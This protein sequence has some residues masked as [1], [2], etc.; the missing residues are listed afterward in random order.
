M[1]ISSQP[2]HSQVPNLVTIKAMAPSTQRAIV[3]K[4]DGAQKSLVIKEKT[5]PTVGDQDIL[6]KVKAVTLNP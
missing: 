4:E 6:I 1:I 3:V 2:S 5:I